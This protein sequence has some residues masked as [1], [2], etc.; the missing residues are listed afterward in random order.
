MKNNTKKKEKAQNI[1]K[2]SFNS[3]NQNKLHKSFNDKKRNKI[4]LNNNIDTQELTDIKLN[5]IIVL[6]KYMIYLIF[7][8]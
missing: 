7:K 2:D 8:K 6:K 1:L 5:V 3:L 4:H